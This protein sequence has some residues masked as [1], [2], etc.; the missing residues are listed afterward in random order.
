MV[1][2][3]YDNVVYS[4]M[5]KLMHTVPARLCRIIVSILLVVGLAGLPAFSSEGSG[6]SSDC[7]MHLHGAADMGCC[8]AK[9]IHRTL[10]SAEVDTHHTPCPFP[11]NSCDG[12]SCFTATGD[13]TTLASGGSL[14]D[15]GS[16]TLYPDG[17]IDLFV[18][19]STVKIPLEFLHY[20]VSSPIYK[21]MCVYLI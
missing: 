13:I 8:T 4:R 3:Q 17:L 19:G 10:S 15:A 20:L 1:D 21:R 5:V 2:G 9:N 16:S 6:C 11:E 7:L 14:P 18:L 12:L